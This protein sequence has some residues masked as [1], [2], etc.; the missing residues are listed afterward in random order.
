MW[1]A[2]DPR[3]AYYASYC[4][5]DQAVT[6]FIN[7]LFSGRWLAC[8]LT[9]LWCFV[10]FSIFPSVSYFAF[11]YSWLFLSPFR[12][13]LSF[14]HSAKF[15]DLLLLSF[16]SFFFPLFTYLFFLHSTSRYFYLCNLCHS[17]L[18]VRKCK[19]FVLL[20]D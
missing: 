18:F 4:C 14:I 5:V 15:L 3:L 10:F 19:L 6:I 1:C 17:F 11:F 20:V 8:W 9:T 16:I 7:Y 13:I 12:Y 2:P